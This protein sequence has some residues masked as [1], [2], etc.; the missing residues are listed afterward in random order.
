MTTTTSDERASGDEWHGEICDPDR[1][2][3]GGYHEHGVCVGVVEILGG[4]VAIWAEQ[5]QRPGAPVVI[6]IEW[7]R[8]TY[9]G[10]AS[11]VRGGLTRVGSYLDRIPLQ[12]AG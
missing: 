12:R 6:V 7:G 3:P 5:E 1:R 11:D 4:D 2:K 8:E 9:R 10:P